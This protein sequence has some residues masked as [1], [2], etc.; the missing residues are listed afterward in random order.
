MTR[1]TGAILLIV[2]G[3]I[4][5]LTNNGI[6]SERFWPQLAS[7]WPLTLVL[8]GIKI[9]FGKSR[10]TQA[11]IL[12]VVLSAIAMSIALTLKVFGNTTIFK[13]IQPRSTREIYEIDP[14]SQ[15]PY[16][17]HVR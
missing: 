15:R 13:R 16:R 3:L 2:L 11:I 17:I 8:I 12:A 10:L 1:Q 6:L 9:I 4:L 7:F 14:F 5:F